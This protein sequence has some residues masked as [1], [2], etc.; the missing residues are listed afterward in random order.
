M[1]KKEP[2]ISK[3]GRTILIVTAAVILTVAA[4]AAFFI[5]NMKN[6]PNQ[7]SE[8]T[9]GA[10]NPASGSLK[11]ETTLTFIGRA[12]VKLVTKEG[13]VIYIDPYYPLGDYS[14]P[15]DYILI[16]HEHSDH[17]DPSICTQ[18]E[19]CE[20]IKWS[21][22]L[23]D[24]EYKSYDFGNIKV[25]TVPSG[26]NINHSV[27]NCVGYIVTVDGVSVYHAGDTSMSD[28]LKT[29]I[30]KHI[31]YAMYPVDGEYNMGPEEASEVANMI[32]ATNNIPIH[33]NYRLFAKQCEEFSADGKLVL[34]DGE[35]IVLTASK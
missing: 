2:K 10:S 28:G 1:D 32:G 26:G 17:N 6:V 7:L 23:V 14:E 33:G 22:A 24:G 27:T 15:A 8:N 16:T 3:K 34:T 18:N 19:G 11:G 25:E 35:T 9:Q 21:D 12:S 30:G 4:V 5:G 20:I 13:K 31:D 29:L